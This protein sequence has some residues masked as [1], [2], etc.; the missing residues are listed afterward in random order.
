MDLE[1]AFFAAQSQGTPEDTRPAG[2]ERSSSV[3][4]ICDPGAGV[5]ED[6]R[7][8]GHDGSSVTFIGDPEAGVGERGD[9]GCSG[10]VQKSVALLCIDFDDTLTQ[11]DTTSLL[12]KIA[13]AQASL[14][15][16]SRNSSSPEW[17]SK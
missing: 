2:H 1:Y 15:H 10:G 12:V 3:T 6:T 9:R 17:S 4:F 8:A 11:D 5:A 13:A 14:L 16:L 7:P